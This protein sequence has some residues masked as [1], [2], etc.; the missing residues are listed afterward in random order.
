MEYCCHFWAG[1]L[2]C[3]FEFLDKRKKRISWDPLDHT[4]N[5]AS[6]SLFDNITLVY[7]HLNWLNW[8]HFLIL[9]GA[10]LFIQIDCMIFLSPLL[11]V[12]KMSMSTVS[13]LSQLGSGILFIE[14]FP[15]TY[16]LNGFNSRINRHFLTVGCF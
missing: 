13:F 10:L 5:I 2:S 7:V 8:F 14:C 4:R 15:L 12:T 3:Y 9:E 11:D 1:A 16:G 6:L